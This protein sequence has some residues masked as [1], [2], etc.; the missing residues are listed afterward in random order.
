M[1]TVVACGDG[2]R[3]EAELGE[4][5]VLARETDFVVSV[6]QTLPSF[7][8]QSPPTCVPHGSGFHLN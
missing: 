3:S 8:P 4:V 7:P 5:T 1:H 6:L 2:Q